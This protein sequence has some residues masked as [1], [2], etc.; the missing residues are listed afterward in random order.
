[1]FPVERGQLKERMSSRGLPVHNISSITTGDTRGWILSWEYPGTRLA[2]R[3]WVT[4][5]AESSGKAKGG[6]LCWSDCEDMWRPLRF[7]AAV[8]PVVL[9]SNHTLSQ[10]FEL[11]LFNTHDINYQVL[12]VRLNDHSLTNVD[13]I[14]HSPSP[15][16][17]HLNPCFTWP[18]QAC[19]DLWMPTSLA[20]VVSSSPRWLLEMQL[21]PRNPSYPELDFSGQQTLDHHA[22]RAPRSTKVHSQLKWP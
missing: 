16:G 8:A 2:E 7:Y 17:S 6:K 10:P 1:M 21:C 11:I 19:L 5:F 22:V 12:T 15:T 18:R 9:W 4:C 20:G 14:K 13:N 3:N